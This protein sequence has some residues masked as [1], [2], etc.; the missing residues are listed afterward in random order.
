MIGWIVA[1]AADALLRKSAAA[2]NIARTKRLIVT[3]LRERDT[4]PHSAA[5]SL[6]IRCSRLCWLIK[7]LG[8]SL[9]GVGERFHPWGTLPPVRRHQ[10]S[11]NSPLVKTLLGW[12]IAAVP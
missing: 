11:Q 10:G 3:P 2:T 6:Y 9:L 12:R 7:I 4:Q 5:R 1:E 8:V